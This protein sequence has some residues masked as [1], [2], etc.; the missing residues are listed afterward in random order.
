MKTSTFIEYINNR[1]ESDS[2][3]REDLATTAGDITSLIPQTEDEMFLLGKLG[4]YPADT[5]APFVTRQGTPFYEFD[6]MAMMPKGGKTMKYLDFEFRQLEILFHLPPSQQHRR[7]KLA[8]K[9]PIPRLQ[10]GCPQKDRI[11]GKIPRTPPTRLGRNTSRVDE[12]LS[13]FQIQ[14]LGRIPQPTP[15]DRPHT[16]RRR[17]Q[18]KLPLTPILGS[19][20]R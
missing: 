11:Q 7:P 15:L 18:N 20:T 6:N 3:L 5:C 14:K 17:N 10:S 1:I 12:I 9:Q 4:L 16:H 13:Q 8:P 19:R 2:K